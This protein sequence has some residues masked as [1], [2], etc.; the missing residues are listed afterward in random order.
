VRYAIERE[1][2]SSPSGGQPRG[3][4]SRNDQSLASRD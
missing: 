1:L 2:L 4:S 3:R